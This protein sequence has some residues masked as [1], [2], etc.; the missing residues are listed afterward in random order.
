MRIICP[1]CGAQYEVPTD[2]IP[3][4]GRDV[5]CSNCGTTW[6]QRHPS[7]DRDL[8]EELG[9]N[10]VRDDW[11]NPAPEQSAALSPAQAPD[12]TPESENHAASNADLP[13]LD[14]NYDEDY[15]AAPS[16]K[17]AAALRRQLDPAVADLLREEAEREARARAADLA[18]ADPLESQPD[19]GLEP[20]DEL[21]RQQREA[22][23]RMSHLKGEAPPPRNIPRPPVQAEAP[24]APPIN[25]ASRREL[26]PDIDQINS[27]LR[28]A[29]E[30]RPAQ[31]DDHE[32]PGETKRPPQDAAATTSGFRRG[33]L[34][35]LL[36]A[37][38]VALLYIYAPQL[39]ELVPALGP[40]VAKATQTIDVARL[41]LDGQAQ[42]LL[43]WLDSLA[44]GGS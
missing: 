31:A 21:S 9:E 40:L 10:P 39:T 20:E 42:Q 29:T 41:W 18:Q 27:T 22:R 24:P 28:G 34:V 32:T 19:F 7:Q 2:V 23:E 44:S 11:S 14:E 36:L 13:P 37:V 35:S 16:V 43:T 26:L 3:E 33:F 5:Q 1:N 38:A 6:F 4:V 25:P 15:D 30:K 12:P 17:P 8:A